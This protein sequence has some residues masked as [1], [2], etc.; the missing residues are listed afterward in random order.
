MAYIESER[1][2]SVA[3]IRMNNAAE[4]ME[5]IFNYLCRI[6]YLLWRN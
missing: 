1:L 3:D 5:V 4:V 6:I 2:L